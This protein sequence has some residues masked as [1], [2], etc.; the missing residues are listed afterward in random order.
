[1]QVVKTTPPAIQSAV[2]RSEAAATAEAEVASA[3]ARMG[4]ERCLGPHVLIDPRPLA[5]TALSQLVAEHSVSSGSL[6]CAL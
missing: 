4:L 2:D 1:M 3:P 5:Q 6:G